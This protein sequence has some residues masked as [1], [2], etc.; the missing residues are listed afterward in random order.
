MNDLTSPAAQFRQQAQYEA[1]VQAALAVAM[2]GYLGDVETLARREGAYITPAG[3]A[4][5]WE[6]WMGFEALR[7]N[8]D[9]PVAAYVARSQAL[10][11]TPADTYDLVMQVFSAST[12][13]EWST[14]L[15]DDVLALAL[16]YDPP[17][18]TAAAMPKPGSR[19]RT[20]MTE[21]FDRA[22]E[23]GRIRWGD[24]VATDS[25]TAA[26]GLQG[27]V[28]MTR[29]RLDGFGYKQWVTRRDARVRDSHR[30]ADGQRV[31]IGDEFTVGGTSLDHPGDW[32]GSADETINCRCVM[33][34]TRTP[35]S[36]STALPFIAP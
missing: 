7:V 24:R 33:V 25:K 15:T 4:Y 28:A 29:A 8:L 9:E 26:T 34:A 1:Q 14:T 19:R 20:A 31:P 3:I 12:A 27:S 36:G 10:S 5:T 32:Q 16:A 35:A 22:F 23:E 11:T 18:L 13:N 6:G 2:Q 21:A 17:V 30:F